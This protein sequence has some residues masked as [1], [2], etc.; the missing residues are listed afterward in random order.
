MNTKTPFI[1]LLPCLLLSRANA[2][3]LDPT[4]FTGHATITFSGYAGGETLT[5]FPALV[6]LARD[7]PK[8]FHYADCA[9]GGS[10]LRFTGADGTVLDHEID[11]WDPNGTSLVWVRLPALSGTDTAITAYWGKHGASP[12]PAVTPANVWT[13][14]VS[15]WHLNTGLGDSGSDANPLS[16]QINTT[17]GVP[18]LLGSGCHQDGTTGQYLMTEHPITNANGTARQTFTVSG[19]FKPEKDYLASNL[20]LFST[21]ENGGHSG[22]GF[23]VIIA[24]NKLLM[25]GN[26]NSKT[27]GSYATAWADNFTIGSWTQIAGVFNG[28]AAR[29]FSA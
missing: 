2:E 8:N 26:G 17:C 7:T 15:V 14:Y 22:N 28:S 16:A 11:T 10:D 23:E 19:W 21:K 1:L 20:R 13:R 5:D 9:A 6:K 24:S 29:S 3:T 25:R 4:L 27:Y 18:A 12:L